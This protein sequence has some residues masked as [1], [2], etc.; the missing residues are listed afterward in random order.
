[1]KRWPWRS[2]AVTATIVVIIVVAIGIWQAKTCEARANECIS[3]PVMSGEPNKPAPPVEAIQACR[4]SQGYFCRM[5]APAN[6][7][8]ILLV[9]AGFLGIFAAFSTLKIL[10]RQTQATE[11]A[12]KA[13]KASADTLIASERGFLKA[14]LVRE[15][16]KYGGHWFKTEPYKVALTSDELKD[17]LYYRY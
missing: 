9:L 17:G 3:N 13:A 2:I 1:M 5:L 16:S 8:N 12:A 4:E 10:E 15:A 7:P 11:D 6:F 14:D